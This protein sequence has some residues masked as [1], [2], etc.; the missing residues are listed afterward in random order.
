MRKLL[1]KIDFSKWRLNN[2]VVLTGAY[3][4]NL[5]Q[6]VNFAMKTLFYKKIREGKGTFNRFRTC[7]N[8]ISNP[9]DMVNR[10]NLSE[11]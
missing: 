10:V 6:K 8:G 1:F 5:C 3:R 11:L 7:I 2:S 9:V 4:E